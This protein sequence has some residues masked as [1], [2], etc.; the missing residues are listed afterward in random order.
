MKDRDSTQTP[1]KSNRVLPRSMQKPTTSFRDLQQETDQNR[2]DVVGAVADCIQTEKQLEEFRAKRA[3][4]KL[5]EL[6]KGIAPSHP[7][8]SL[9]GVCVLPS[10]GGDMTGANEQE[11]RRKLDAAKAKAE[12]H[13]KRAEA[14]L[15]RVKNE[16][17]KAQSIAPPRIDSERFGH[18]TDDVEAI[19]L[20]AVDALLVIVDQ[21]E[22]TIRTA[23]KYL[24]AADLIHRSRDHATQLTR[25]PFDAPP[26]K[27]E[28]KNQTTSQSSRSSTSGGGVRRGR[29]LRSQWRVVDL[30]DSSSQ[31]GLSGPQ[32]LRSPATSDFHSGRNIGRAPGM[33]RGGVKR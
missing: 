9:P 22:E 1:S 24:A 20:Q 13:I 7:F 11:L 6:D 5:T 16:A 33:T 10:L 17:D 14:L 32:I 19:R 18:V 25:Q 30:P 29:A 12:G 21:I 31:K 2:N 23:E 28:S 8:P 3:Q 4:D 26:S 15:A 27:T